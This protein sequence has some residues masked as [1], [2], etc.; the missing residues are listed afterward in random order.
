MVALH[1][2]EFLNEKVEI[3]P[4]PHLDLNKDRVKGN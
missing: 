2:V 1:W 3:V 4:F